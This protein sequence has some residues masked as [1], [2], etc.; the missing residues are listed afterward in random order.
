MIDTLD[1]FAWLT[2]EK[3]KQPNKT[4]NE[5]KNQIWQ[6]EREREEWVSDLFNI[7]LYVIVYFAI[8]Y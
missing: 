4:S 2:K 6:G 8:L 3:K 5:L 1:R 7:E